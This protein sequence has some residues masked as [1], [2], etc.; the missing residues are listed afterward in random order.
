[1]ALQEDQ[2]DDGEEER[3]QLQGDLQHF[4]NA[5]A[6]NTARAEIVEAPRDSNQ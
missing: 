1:M 3:R 6:A 2:S 4:L 5:S